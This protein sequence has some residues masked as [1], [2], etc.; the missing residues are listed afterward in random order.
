MSIPIDGGCKEHNFVHCQGFRAK[1]QVS[2]ISPVTPGHNY[3]A[4]TRLANSN[5]LSDKFGFGRHV[6]P[7]F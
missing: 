7:A 3:N 1:V 4:S 2:L 5:K 6:L